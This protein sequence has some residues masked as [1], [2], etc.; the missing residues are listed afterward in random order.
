[1]RIEND[2]PRLEAL[3]RYFLSEKLE[4]LMDYRSKGRY[5]GEEFDLLQEI[6]HEKIDAADGTLREELAKPPAPSPLP[7]ALRSEQPP[8]L[9]PDEVAMEM[10]EKHEPPANGT[11]TGEFAAKKFIKDITFESNR[12]PRIKFD[13][14]GRSA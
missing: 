6:I 10:E 13:L 5:V 12:G 2:T 7:P 8:I 9:S 14:P 3:R 4:E 11:G 1:M